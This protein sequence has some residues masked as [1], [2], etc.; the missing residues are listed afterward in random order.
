MNDQISTDP[1]LADAVWR[2]SARSSPSGDN[3]VEVAFVPAGVAVRDSKN[4]GG[5]AL[6]FTEQEWAAFVAGTKDGEFDL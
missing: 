5:G 1:M 4:P 2:K 3:C 6:L